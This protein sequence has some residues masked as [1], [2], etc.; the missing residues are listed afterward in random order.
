MDQEPSR[1]S[2]LDKFSLLRPLLSV[3]AG[4]GIL[5]YYPSTTSFDLALGPDSPPADEPSGGTLRISGHWILTNVCATQA[6]I[7]T[8]ALSTSTYVNAS[9]YNRT[10]PYRYYKY[11]TASANYLSPI[12]FRRRTTRPVSYY[13]LFKGLL[14]L[15]QPPGCLSLPTSFTT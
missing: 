2:G 15:S 6:D 5:T 9:S 12:H 1:K 10:L 14:L 7:L 13:A 3:K 8:S 4:I 11:L